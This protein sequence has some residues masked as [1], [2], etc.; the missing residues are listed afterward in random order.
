MSGT[1][2][3]GP[4]VFDILARGFA[5]EGV[6]VCFALLGDA[7]MSW[8]TRLA[9]QGCRMIYVRHEHCAVASAMAF[10]RKPGKVG[11]AFRSRTGSYLPLSDERI[12]RASAPERSHEESA[13]SS[14]SLARHRRN[15]L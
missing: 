10:A 9:E 4:R 7:N 15:L 12:R 6:E 5:Q 13:Q 2:M 1:P 14:I 8:A 11:V 3:A